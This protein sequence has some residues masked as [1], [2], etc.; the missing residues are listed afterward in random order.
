MDGTRQPN[1]TLVR[2]PLILASAALAAILT[3]VVVLA[4]ASPG[5][6]SPHVDSAVLYGGHWFE[7]GNACGTLRGD[8]EFTPDTVTAH[9]AG[10][11]AL[12][13][14]VLSVAQKPPDG[15]ELKLQSFDGSLTTFMPITVKDATTIILHDGL[16]EG[17]W[18]KCP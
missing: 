9:E 1:T 7:N 12:R 10:H 13:M 4:V 11:V 18:H 16:Q 8:F 6:R 5:L 15:L 17:I 14:R 2:R 3:A